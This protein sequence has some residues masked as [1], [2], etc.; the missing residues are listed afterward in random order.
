M[1]RSCVQG[2]VL[3]LSMVLCV[4][5]SAQ[6]AAPKLPADADQ[7]LLK[8]ATASHDEELA[9]AKA[10]QKEAMDVAQ[11]TT[12][13]LDKC[14]SLITVWEKDIVPLLT[15]DDGKFLAAQPDY[16]Q[17]FNG[18][19]NSERPTQREI[20]R[21]RESLNTLTG[22]L[23]AALGK[24][25][26]TY[27]PTPSFTSQLNQSKEKAALFVTGYEEPIRMIKAL[28]ARAQKEGKKGSETLSAA[29]DQLA[30]DT[31]LKKG[32]E[33]SFQLKAKQEETSKRIADA[34]QQAVE[35]KATLAENAAKQDTQIAHEQ[36]DKEALTKLAKSPDIQKRLAPFITPG[37]TQ[38][39][40]NRSGAIVKVPDEAKPLSFSGLNGKGALA[41]TDDGRTTLVWIATNNRND[42]PKWTKPVTSEEWKWVKENQEYLRKLGPVLV[43]LGMLSP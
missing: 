38:V 3:V 9:T 24:P 13:L 20:D 1:L 8:E 33:L 10:R 35:E 5:A 21:L 6:D 27:T 15:N 31:A 2:F 4:L 22:P 14:G 34:Q 25:D 39:I 36:A 11:D 19:Y 28:L 7:I 40:P 41:P 12:E 16:V 43:E 18:Y 17:A 32:Q 37:M 29:V 30:A 26:N 42:R 23:K